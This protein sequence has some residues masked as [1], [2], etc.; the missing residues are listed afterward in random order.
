[1]AGQPGAGEMPSNAYSGEALA[2]RRRSMFAPGGN[3]LAYKRAFS[4]RRVDAL[5]IMACGK[6]CIQ[7]CWKSVTRNFRHNEIYGARAYERNL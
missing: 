4:A 2:P 6:I 7:N 1:M 5:M 3:H